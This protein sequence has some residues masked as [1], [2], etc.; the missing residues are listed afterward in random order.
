ASRRI[1]NL[2]GDFFGA[3]REL[4]IVTGDEL[5]NATP[6][7]VFDPTTLG[8]GNSTTFQVV[9]PG[10]SV[11]GRQKPSE[12]NSPWTRDRFF[13]NYTYLA[14]TS[15][16]EGGVGVHRIV[17]GLERSFAD[18][19][20]SWEIRLPA[21]ITFDSESILN[22]GSSRDQGELGNIY[23][24]TKVLL[25]S[26]SDF[27]MAAGLGGNFPTAD[28]LQ[29]ANTNNRE[30]VRVENSAVHL[31][32]FLSAAW[33]ED[34]RGWFAQSFLQLDYDLNGNPVLID[35]GTELSDVGD[36]KDATYLYWDTSIGY[37]L[38]KDRWGAIS[39]IAPV[40]EVHYNTAL[41]TPDGVRSNS[42]I[43][44]GV[45]RGQVEVVNLLFGINLEIAN[46][47]SLAI[48]YGTPIGGGDDEQFDSELR[49][50]LNCN[51][52]GQ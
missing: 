33:S 28:D 16:Q 31:M 45:N 44:F 51:F 18:G 3:G 30:L 14:N 34:D 46:R 50:L 43:Q 39:G 49:I 48:G 5:L 2:M 7:D 38:I 22:G 42:G 27:V 47:H 21:G 41:D 20:A 1:P 23:L 4:L 24:G 29:I 12:N 8:T 26:S 11:L 15:L 10:S 19:M 17:P 32:P 13:L 36:F 9:D 35:N 6:S 37:W 25:R 40:M 52:G